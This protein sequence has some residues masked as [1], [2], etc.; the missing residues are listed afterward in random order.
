MSDPAAD[1]LRPEHAL[2]ATDAG[3]WDAEVTIH[4]G[5]GAPPL[6]SRGVS[7]GRMGCG[8]R[9]LLVDFKNETGFEGHGVYGYDPARR[10]FVG[11]WVDNLREFLVVAVGSY[12]PD[13]RVMTYVTE[14]TLADGRTLRWREET[15]RTDDDTR[16][17]RQLFPGP[18][19]GDFEMMTVVYRRRTI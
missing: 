14:A 18:D 5:P 11:T 16:R 19:G 15:E 6:P 7:V 12:D 17:F 3:T 2:L 1:T 4:P 13:R 10:A 9:W 8:G